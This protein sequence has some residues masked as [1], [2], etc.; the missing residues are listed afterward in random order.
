VDNFKAL[1]II[2]VLI[3]KECIDCWQFLFDGGYALNRY[4]LYTALLKLD[5][6]L[7]K[8]QFPTIV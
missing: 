7:K 3:S 6:C 1:S 2:T 5:L 8:R 4:I